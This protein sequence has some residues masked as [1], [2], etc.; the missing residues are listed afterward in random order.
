MFKNLTKNIEDPVFL[1]KLN[2]SNE[3]QNLNYHEFCGVLSQI[4]PIYLEQGLFSGRFSVNEQLTILMDSES[5]AEKIQI[6]IKNLVENSRILIPTLAFHDARLKFLKM[7][8][9]N[10]KL[11][12]HDLQKLKEIFDI[13]DGFLKKND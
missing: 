12:S 6:Y 4:N 8:S 11:G 1:A 13:F 10:D 2:L 3:N 5:N 7:H 9:E